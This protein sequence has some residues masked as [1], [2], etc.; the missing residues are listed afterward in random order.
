MTADDLNTAFKAIA[1]AMRKTTT[2]Y[3]AGIEA[4]QCSGDPTRSEDAIRVSREADMDMILA[5]QVA[6]KLVLAAAKSRRKERSHDRKPLDVFCDAANKFERAVTHMADTAKK[7]SEHTD[8]DDDDS[9]VE[10]LREMVTVLNI[11]LEKSVAT[12]N[13]LNSM[14]EM[15]ANTEVTAFK[16]L[17]KSDPNFNVDEAIRASNAARAETA[18]QTQGGGQ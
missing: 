14:S 17:R 15:I 4:E 10:A 5:T 6:A 8:H 9:V 7:I 18:P 13:A 11:A 16:A 1:D 2:A 3:D 12:R